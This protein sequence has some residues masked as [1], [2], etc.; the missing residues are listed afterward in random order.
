MPIYGTPSQSILPG[1]VGLLFGTPA[2]PGST[3]AYPAAAEVIAADEKSRPVVIPAVNSGTTN[4]QRQLSWQVTGTGSF[5]FN[6]QVAIEDVD[7][8]YT[9]IANYTGTNGSGLLGVQSDGVTESQATSK[10][11]A[12]ARFIRCVEASGSPVTATVKVTCL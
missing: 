5:N 2:Y 6:L 7:A 1:Q 9:T 10:V 8:E 11:L 4:T 3:P 12:A